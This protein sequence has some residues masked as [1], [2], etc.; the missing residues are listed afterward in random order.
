MNKLNLYSLALFF[1]IFFSMTACQNENNMTTEIAPF[2]RD[3]TFQE[4]SKK[5]KQEIQEALDKVNQKTLLLQTELEQVEGTAQKEIKASIK[6]LKT[7]DK[8]LKAAF[9]YIH[10]NAINDWRHFNSN[11]KDIISELE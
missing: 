1:G 2:V 5:L 7:K 6:I 11:V 9:D 10:R 8:K 4:Q 3:E